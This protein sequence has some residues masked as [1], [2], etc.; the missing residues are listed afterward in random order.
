MQP[1]HI[2][3]TESYKDNPYPVRSG[4]KREKYLWA[5]QTIMK[6]G[7][8]VCFGSDYPVV[9]IDPFLG[10][11]RSVT[12]LHNDG[13]PEGGWNPQEKLTVQ[14]ALRAYTYGSAYALGREEELGTLEAGKYADIVVLDKNLLTVPP[15]RIRGTKSILT[16][17]NGKVVFEE[18]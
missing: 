5:I 15:E 10:I 13:T 2:A 3:L 17:I 6:T 9:D 12:R 1:E 8:N 11:Y 7:T 14:E 16:M 4:K 18:E